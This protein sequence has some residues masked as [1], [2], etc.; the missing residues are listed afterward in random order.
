M[1]D[2]L[3]GVNKPGEFATVFH[4]F[5]MDSLAF[6][7]MDLDLFYQFFGEFCESNCITGTTQFFIDEFVSAAVV[8]HRVEMSDDFEL[9]ERL[10]NGGSITI[11]KSNADTLLKLNEELENEELNSLLVNFTNEAISVENCISRLR[12][13]TRL[14]LDVNQELEFVAGNFFEF[15]IS[16]LS[17]LSVSEFESV[18]VHE[19]LQ[20]ESENSLLDCI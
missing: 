13:K 8:S 10:W 4:T 18:L 5:C 17:S 16:D 2:A 1:F 12:L 6:D 7:G 20:I 9:I 11:N 14:G 3:H 19:S 15:N